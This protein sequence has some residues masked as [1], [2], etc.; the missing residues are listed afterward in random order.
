ML[1]VII[2]FIAKTLHNNPHQISLFWPMICKHALVWSLCWALASHSLWAQAIAP[3][4]QIDQT[5]G[6]SEADEFRELVLAPDGGLLLLGSTLSRDGV[7]KGQRGK[8]D[9]WLVRTN[10]DGSIRWQKCLGGGNSDYPNGLARISNGYVVLAGSSSTDGDLAGLSPQNMDAWVVWL[11]DNGA[12]RQQTLL[13]GP[14]MDKL[15]R[16]IELPNGNFAFVGEQGAATGADADIWLVITGPDGKVLQQKTYGG[17]SFDRANDMIPT[18]DGGFL[19]VGQ[20]Y[21]SD[22]GVTNAGG[23]DFWVVRLNPDLSVAWQRSIGKAGMDVANAAV[24]LKD[25]SFLVAGNAQSIEPGK[26]VYEGEIDGWLVKLAADGSTEWERHLG[27]RDH[28]M[29]CRLIATSSGGFVVAG[30]YGEGRTDHDM[31]AW[32]AELNANGDI[33]WQHKLSGWGGA[34]FNGV[35]ETAPGEFALAGWTRKDR[36]AKNEAWLVRLTNQV[37][38]QLTL[39]DSLTAK[40]LAADLALVPVGK[41]GLISLQTASNGTAEQWLS[42]GKYQLSLK[43]PGYTERL[44]S[45]EIKQQPGGKPQPLPLKLA[46]LRAGAR[47][48]LNK[49]YFEQKSAVLTDAS[50]AELDKVVSLLKDRPTVRIRIEGHT[51]SGGREELNVALSQQRAQAV[52]DYLVQKGIDTARLEA[53]GYGSSRPVADN[54]DEEGQRLNRRIEFEIIAE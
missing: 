37:K 11:D 13:G 36:T 30:W 19:I 4:P 38:V 17:A 23:G 12:I 26:S 28:E 6:G 25:G 29:L 50:F 27:G 33:R 52:K 2:Y 51:A 15:Y 8:S 53:V 43:K 3:S 54:A 10:A 24:E 20:T 35:I 21:S 22:R 7:V 47:V 45:I 32:V 9:V 5:Y 1:F 49:I 14:G 41:T 18:R 46:P 48:T 31:A 34:S 39:T 44:V 16:A 40:P 42:P